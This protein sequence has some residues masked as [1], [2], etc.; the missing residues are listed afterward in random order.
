MVCEIKNLSIAR[1]SRSECCYSIVDR[2]LKNTVQMTY[3][4]TSQK[5]FGFKDS[6]PNLREPTT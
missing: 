6:F 3:R 1:F 2:L 5:F 4:D